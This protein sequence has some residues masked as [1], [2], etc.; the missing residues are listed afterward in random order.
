MTT[1]QTSRDAYETIKPKL[2][3]QQLTI[4]LALKAL[5]SATADRVADYLADSKAWPQ[6]TVAARLNSLEQA[7]YVVRIGKAKNKSGI[8]ATLWA[9]T[10]PNDKN[11]RIF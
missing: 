11:L 3:E 7:G 6:S 4:W 9:A 10:D 2:G 5:T 8:L 1:A